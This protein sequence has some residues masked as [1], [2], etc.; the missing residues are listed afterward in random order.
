[1]MET[2]LDKV[3]ATFLLSCA[4]YFFPLPLFAQQQVFHFNVPPDLQTS[5]VHT[6][7]YKVP[8]HVVYDICYKGKMIAPSEDWLEQATYIIPN[9]IPLIWYWR[10]AIKGITTLAPQGPV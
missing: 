7:L 3:I 10:R 6:Y 4:C 1:M 5:S 9:G 8:P 2:F